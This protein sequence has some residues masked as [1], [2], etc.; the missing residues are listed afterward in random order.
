MAKDFYSIHGISSQS[1]DDRIAR[2]EKQMEQ[3][4]PIFELFSELQSAM[5][6]FQSSWQSVVLSSST[7]DAEITISKEAYQLL[8]NFYDRLC[9]FME[10]TRKTLPGHCLGNTSNSFTPKNPLE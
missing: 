5:N 10:H 3:I 9:A 1:I 7:A 4:A 2:L 6:T 8:G